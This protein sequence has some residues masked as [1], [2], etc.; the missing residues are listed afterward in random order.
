VNSRDLR[1]LQV[2]IAL[3][4]HL[5]ASLPDSTIAVAES[6]LRSADDL[7][8]LRALRYDAFLIGERLM[9]EPD[10]GSALASLRLAAEGVAP[11]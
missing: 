4:D 10:P 5:A 3:F 6:G 2:D 1:T 7:V 11:R 8:R 9:T